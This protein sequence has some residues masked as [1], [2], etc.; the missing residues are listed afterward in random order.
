MHRLCFISI[1]MR[2]RG[3]EMG[4]FSPSL[5]SRTVWLLLVIACVLARWVMLR[6]GGQLS[7]KRVLIVSA[8]WYIC[9][10][11]KSEGEVKNSEVLGRPKAFLLKRGG[12]IY[13]TVK[14]GGDSGGHG[15]LPMNLVLSSLYPV[16]YPG[17]VMGAVV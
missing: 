6:Q 5:L 10:T 15:N 11:A 3:A 16:V 2:E 13:N 7:T 12:C 4:D 1:L 14:P 8:S 9:V 17:W